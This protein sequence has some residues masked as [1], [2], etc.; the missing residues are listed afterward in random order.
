MRQLGDEPL[1][2]G[3]HAEGD[4]LDR[5]EGRLEGHV[6]VELRGRG[7]GGE[8][9]AVLAAGP[10]PDLGAVGAQPVLDGVARQVGQVAQGAEAEPLQQADQV[11]A[12]AAVVLQHVHGQAAQERRGAA[13]RDDHPR[14]DV[15]GACRLLGGEEVV[16]DADPHVPDATL[17]QGLAR[18][19]GGRGLG[20]V[21]AAGGSH[22]E[23]AGAQRRHPGTQVL[24]E[25]QDRLEGPGV[26]V[27]VGRQQHQLGAPGLGVAP[28]L[29]APHALGCGRGRCTPRRRW[30]RGRRRG[31][32]CDRP[33]SSSAATTDQSGHHTT[34]TLIGGSP[35]RLADLAHPAVDA[36]LDLVHPRPGQVLPP[37]RARSAAYD[38][39]G[40]TLPQVPGAGRPDR[41]SRRPRRRPW[42]RPAASRRGPRAPRSASAAA[43]RG[44]PP[45]SRRRRPAAA[46]PRPGARR[47]APPSP[48]ASARPGRGP[49]RCGTARCPARPP[50]RHRSRRT[51]RSRSTPRPGRLR[52]PARAPAR[53]SR[54][55]T[56]IRPASGTRSAR[57]G[58]VATG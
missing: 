22:G 16:G 4:R 45:S 29:S 56:S 2:G 50:P 51:R 35:G 18:R 17:D 12:P 8:E 58:N 42:P 11:P 1:R 40:A 57:P 9:G 32:G 27:G 14:L 47:P 13:G 26:A 36:W 54:R 38:D 21:P 34:M 33:A 53:R 44:A 10:S 30:R 46:A 25:G 5:V 31:S 6:G 49:A 52:R 43:S 55:R 39:A 15:G 7:A 48:R 20:A 23:Q 28:A 41:P 24:D 3:A 19:R 37:R